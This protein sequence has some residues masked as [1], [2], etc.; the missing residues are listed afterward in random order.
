VPQGVGEGRVLRPGERREP[1]A[2]VHHEVGLTPEL[3]LPPD[4]GA[5]DNLR[6]EGARPEGRRE[7]EVAPGTEPEEIEMLDLCP[8]KAEVEQA[9]FP[10]ASD[11]GGGPPA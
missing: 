2:T 7:V 10:H 11:P 1:E 4:H 3:P 9:D 6:G 5:P 8:C